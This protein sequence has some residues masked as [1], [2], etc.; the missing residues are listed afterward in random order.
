MVVLTILSIA[1]DVWRSR[2]ITTESIPSIAPSTLKGGWIDINKMS[3]NKPVLVYFWATW[4]PV[5]DFVS[6]SVNW[7]S[8]NYQV[9]S[10][11]IT[12]GDTKR[13]KQYMQYKEY[14]FDVIN[15]ATGSISRQWGVS[16]TPSVFIVNKG[17]ISSITT[18][19][20]TP[21]GLWLRLIF[22]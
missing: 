17:E 18:G 15:D 2:N 14:R 10:V 9:V 8:D 16:V 12:S 4:C 20:T 5:C 22:A 19:A 3:Q 11:A 7:L 13:L 6:P 21:M 1:I